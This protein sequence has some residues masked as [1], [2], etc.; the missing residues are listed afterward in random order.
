MLSKI[1]RFVFSAKNVYLVAVVAVVLQPLASLAIPAQPTNLE[2]SGNPSQP[3]LSWDA[4]NGEATTGD[5]WVKRAGRPAGGT[6]APWS[7]RVNHATTVFDNKMW[8]LG[9]SAGVSPGLFLNDVWYSSD[10]ISWTQATANAAWSARDDHS[11]IT[12]DNK[13]WVMGGNT[14]TGVVNDVWS[15]SD[16][17]NWTE[18]TPSAEWSARKG[19]AV[20]VFNDELWLVGGILGSGAFL[21]DVWQS[22]NGI[23][24]TRVTAAAPWNPL[25]RPSSVVFDGKLWVMGG[26]QST[27]WYTVNGT[28]WVQAATGVA[29]GGNIN[30][31]LGVIDG[32]MWITSGSYSKDAWTSSDGVTWTKS[33]TNA[34]WV[35]T[36]VNTALTFKDKL[37]L[38]GA[39]YG[40][41][42]P[43]F[44]QVWQS[45]DGMS[46]LP[47]DSTPI[48]GSQLPYKLSSLKAVSFKGSLWV[49]GSNTKGFMEVWYSPDGATWSKTPDSSSLST[50]GGYNL[51]VFNDRIW[52]IGGDDAVGIYTDDVWYSSDGLDWTEATAEAGWPGRAFGHT[53][54][55]Y[56]DL[57]WVIG[58]ESDTTASY[59]IGDV[60][61]SPD[62]ISWTQATANAPWGPRGYHASIVFDNK[63]WVLGG[64]Y[65]DN[66]DDTKDAWSSSDGVNWTQASS[67]TEWSPGYNYNAFVLN[68]GLW[69]IGENEVWKSFDAEN[70]TKVPQTMVWGSRENYTTAVFNEKLWV[71]GGVVE[72]GFPTNEVWST[73]DRTISHYKL[74]WDTVQGGCRNTATSQAVS[75]TLNQPLSPGA[76]YFSV[77]AVNGENE[78]SVL[79]ASTSLVVP[80]GVITTSANQRE[81][82]NDSTQVTDQEVITVDSPQDID[83]EVGEIEKETNQEDNTQDSTD[84]PSDLTMAFVLAA[85]VTAV[86]GWLAYHF[87]TK[88]KNS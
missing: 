27:V 58:G 3:T 42:L 75:Y 69:M 44:K 29:W 23:V 20:K 68:E 43:V 76:W 14:A 70:W 78:E 71:I 37:W 12:F 60:W 7:G 83:T 82:L 80:V 8:V 57:L 28:D 36:S 26:G 21:N 52:L 63:M 46:W 18:A 1:G 47:S 54:V 88:R 6:I 38:L 59:L 25:L 84:K 13:L 65:G 87:N 86:L 5:E 64:I 10:G 9:G 77:R 2:A 51:T 24:W 66:W 53:T 48:G 33:V 85:V 72:D 40:G 30:Y 74:C 61:Y 67:S 81:S 4:V 19:Q 45:A 35:V 11:V 39:A 62:G 79:G 15:S 22:N 16:G 41:Y 73:P 49:V 55:V 17:V 50:R 34:D 56:N 31:A 32:K